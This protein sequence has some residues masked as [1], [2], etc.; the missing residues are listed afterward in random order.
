MI[1]IPGWGG[2]YFIFHPKIAI[3][4]ILNLTSLCLFVLEVK[5]PE[6]KINNVITKYFIS[7]K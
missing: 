2:F 1:V 6:G 7:P 3:H 4:I 5:V